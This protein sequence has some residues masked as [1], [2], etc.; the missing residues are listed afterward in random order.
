MT[1]RWPGVVITIIHASYYCWH[2]QHQRQN[3]H[4]LIRLPLLEPISAQIIWFSIPCIAVGWLTLPEKIL[5]RIEKEISIAC[6]VVLQRCNIAR[7]CLVTEVGYWFILVRNMIMVIH[8]NHATFSWRYQWSFS[9]DV[10][11]LESDLRQIV[12]F[13]F[14]QMILLGSNLWG[15]EMFHIGDDQNNFHY[16]QLSWL[17]LLLTIRIPWYKYSGDEF[18][19][20]VQL[21]FQ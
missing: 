12:S 15:F 16:W 10:L 1:G 9:W 20:R 6:V 4:S 21:D 19:L 5:L 17:F 14:G 18:Y 3:N 2:R 11:V 8:A 7:S 13:P